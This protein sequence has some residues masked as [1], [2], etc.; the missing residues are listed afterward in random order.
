[1]L[2]LT[3]IDLLEL[4][5]LLDG[6]D[7]PSGYFDPDTG[8]TYPVMDGQVIGLGDHD[9]DFPDEYS[10][11][12]ADL[13]PLGGDAAH[14]VYRDM[15]TFTE[16][17][18]NGRVRHELRR[19][20]DGSSP[21]REFRRVVHS[22]PER[23]GPHYSAFSDI[24]SQLRALDFLMGRDVVAAFELEERRAQLLDAGDTVLASLGGGTRA[25]LI[26]LDGLPGV[27]KSTIAKAYVAD[28]PGTL[29]LDIDVLRT[30]LGGE[31]SE[32]AEL[33]R[34]LALSI[35][36]THLSSGYDVVVPQLVADPA[37]LARF[38]SVAKDFAFVLVMVRGES[39]EG[40]Q[41]WRSQVSPAELDAYAEGLHRITRKH[42]GIRLLD[43]VDGD[44][45]ATVAQLEELLGAHV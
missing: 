30:L 40:D 29:N 19:A 28:R 20:L 38:E 33:G 15:E 16:L 36:Q 24:R 31:W 10:A 22:T 6:R 41:A 7:D 45:T 27:G 34:S 21:F 4:G 8:E 2:N 43:V 9:A 25:R 37:Q 1:M 11:E 39:R 32:T 42:R 17:V 23:I 26:L 44:V 12:V 13:V 5:T 3:Q 35:A 18:G 14:E